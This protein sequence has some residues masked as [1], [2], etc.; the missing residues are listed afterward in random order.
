MFHFRLAKLISFDLHSNMVPMIK[1]LACLTAFQTKHSTLRRRYK[2]RLVVW[3]TWGIWE[4]SNCKK[5]WFS[6]LHIVGVNEDVDASSLRL[7]RFLCGDPYW[8]GQF[9]YLCDCSTHTSSISSIPFC[10]SQETDG[11][12]VHWKWYT[13]PTSNVNNLLGSPSFRVKVGE[14]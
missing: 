7:W 13:Y 9:S 12:R 11:S 6:T 2:T 4:V 5:G 10:A 1:S 3:A 8:L 14:N